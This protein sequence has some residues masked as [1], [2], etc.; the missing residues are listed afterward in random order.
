MAILYASNLNNAPPLFNSKKTR[1]MN[2]T[3]L[4]FAILSAL[5]INSET[6]FARNNSQSII[7]NVIYKIISDPGIS[8]RIHIELSPQQDLY[9]FRVNVFLPDSVLLIDKHTT[10]LGLLRKDSV[11]QLEKYIYILRH[12]NFKIKVVVSGQTENGVKVGENGYLY[13]YWNNND[14]VVRI[15]RNANCNSALCLTSLQKLKA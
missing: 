12:S 11:L 4:Q 1:Y 3:I 9:N 10:D 2:H 5:M 15:S 14:Y 7:K 6:S 13:F 8:G